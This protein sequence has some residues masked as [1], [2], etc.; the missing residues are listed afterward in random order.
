METMR[1]AQD[2]VCIS[3]PA[4]AEIET[5]LLHENLWRASQ[6]K[7]ECLRMIALLIFEVD[8][9]NS[10]TIPDGEDIYIEDYGTFIGFWYHAQL[11]KH[12]NAPIHTPALSI[13]ADSDIGIKLA[14]QETP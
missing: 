9:E 10:L 4:F 12:S 11:R 2:T 5:R 8:F 6:M 1:T 7:L 13:S 3:H 14:E